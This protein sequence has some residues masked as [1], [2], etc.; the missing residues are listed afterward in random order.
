MAEQ[1]EQLSLYSVKISTF[2]GPLD[3][4]LHLLK[5]NKI[6][7]YDIPIA[8]ITKQYLEYLEIMKELNLEIASE[9]LVMAATLIYIKSR[10]LLPAPEED[11]EADQAEDPRATLVQRLLEY[12][13]FK[14]MSAQFREREDIWQNAF[15]RPPLE[16]EMIEAEPE[17]L[18]FDVNLFDLMGALRTIL[19]R[20]PPETLTITRETL[21][22]QDRVSFL[23]ERLES[24]P[25]VRFSEMFSGDRSKLQVIVT[26]LALLE[27]LRLGIARAYQEQDFGAIFITR[28]QK[29]ETAESLPDTGQPADHLT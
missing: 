13:A 6:D 20:V 12:Q 19:S 17:P 25:T 24:E 5:Q 8:E 2:E 4:L 29:D 28:V 7:I 23:I 1:P 26:F 21:T 3:L 16:E 18:L 22:V 15:S 10:M 14:E 11:T 27:I 9:F